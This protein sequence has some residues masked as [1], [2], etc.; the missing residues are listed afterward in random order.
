MIFFGERMR[1][2][3]QMALAL[4][5]AGVLVL[6]FWDGKLPWIALTLAF[7]F[8]FYGV[9]RKQAAVDGTVGLTVE[10]L[11]LTPVCLFYLAICAF[12]GQLAFG[13]LN[14]GTDVLIILSGAVTSIPLICFAHAIQRLRLVTIGFLQ[15]I[16]PTLAFLIAVL[17]YNESFPP[18]Y[19]VGVGLIWCG[20]AL[21]VADAIRQMQKAKAAEVVPLD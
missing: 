15:Y 3:Q 13:N 10:T 14:R 20:V 19:Q 9:L 12:E 6:T 4:A 11:L 2:P 21:F 17:F 18:P 16:S 5:F 7:T 1:G 8:S